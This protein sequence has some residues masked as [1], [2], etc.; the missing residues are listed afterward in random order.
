MAP[1]RLKNLVSVDS[2]I[3]IQHHDANASF[4]P[5]IT[6]QSVFGFFNVIIFKRLRALVYLLLRDIPITAV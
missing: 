3:I 5:K 6:F 1:Y 2:Q 4:L